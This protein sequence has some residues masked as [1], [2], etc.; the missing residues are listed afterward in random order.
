MNKDTYELLV[1][2]R[3][4]AA[5][6]ASAAAQ[7]R[8]WAMLLTIAFFGGLLAS[9]AGIGGVLVVISLA[10]IVAGIIWWIMAIRDT[11]KK[12]ERLDVA[13]RRLDS[14]IAKQQQ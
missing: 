9:M 5:S 1:H 8:I 12:R 7:W 11:A 13:Q 10:G 4:L 14:F 2:D 3:D 6:E